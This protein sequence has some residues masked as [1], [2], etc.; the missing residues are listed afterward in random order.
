MILCRCSSITPG[1]GTVTCVCDISSDAPNANRVFY[2][3][4]LERLGWT[5]LDKKVLEKLKF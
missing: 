5:G 2:M 4:V 3:N 1:R